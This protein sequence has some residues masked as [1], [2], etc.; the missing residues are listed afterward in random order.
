MTAGDNPYFARNAV[1][2]LWANLMGTG[3]VEPLDDLSGENPA[4][5]PK[6]LEEMAGAF[7]VSG[8]DH[9][10][11]VKGII[12]SQAYQRS[13]AAADESRPDRQLFARARTW[14]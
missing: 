3:L 13:S 2:R 10:L 9:R 6:L 12:L 5:H 8:F 7:V 1:N 14:R 11:V 4:S